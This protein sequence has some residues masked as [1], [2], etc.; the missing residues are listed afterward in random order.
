MHMANCFA[1]ES[2][3]SAWAPCKLIVRAA[4]F[5]PFQPVLA[6][7]CQSFGFQLRKLRS[8]PLLGLIRHSCLVLQRPYECES[9]LGSAL[10][11]E[12]ESKWGVYKAVC[13]HAKCCKARSLQFGEQRVSGVSSWGPW[14]W[15]WGPRH[16]QTTERPVQPAF[17]SR[18]E[19]NFL[20]INS[21]KAFATRICSYL[22]LTTWLTCIQVSGLFRWPGAAATGSRSHCHH[23]VP[24]SLQSDHFSRLALAAKAKFTPP[25]FIIIALWQHT[26]RNAIGVVV[27]SQPSCRRLLATA[28]NLANV[29]K[30]FLN[31]SAN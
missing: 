18:S 25:A 31:K 2:A 30:K 12:S 28:D 27:V 10:C 9:E 7:P 19:R 20:A 23:G 13:T 15:F 5:L 3:G 4:S 24:S 11:P 14:V 1:S 21:L 16:K 6:L 17:P 22:P 26:H 8:T 29:Q